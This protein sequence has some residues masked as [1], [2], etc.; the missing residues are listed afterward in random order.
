MHI[1]NPHFQIELLGV[2]LIK[3]YAKSSAE[4]K[5]QLL[6]LSQIHGF[7]LNCWEEHTCD[8]KELYEKPESTECMRDLLKIG[9]KNWND[10]CSEEVHDMKGHL[11]TYPIQVKPTSLIMPACHSFTHSL[12]HRPL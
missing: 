8:V 9:E 1:L 3:L 2:P 6:P 4:C 5:K 10:Y 7:R 12:M 11:M